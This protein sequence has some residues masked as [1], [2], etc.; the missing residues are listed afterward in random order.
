MCNLKGHS[1][2]ISLYFPNT[3]SDHTVITPLMVA[4]LLYMLSSYFLVFYCCCVEY[5]G[6]IMQMGWTSTSNSS[7]GNAS[8]NG[9]QFT[10]CLLTLCIIKLNL[11]SW[12][13]VDIYTHITKLHS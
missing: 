2:G 4:Q 7:V 1:H 12:L 11:V 8:S 5:S 9:S 3:Q 10:N 6:I 13:E